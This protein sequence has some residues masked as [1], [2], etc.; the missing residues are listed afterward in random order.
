MS[1]EKNSENRVYSLRTR[2]PKPPKIAEEIYFQ[3]KACLKKN[4]AYSSK[5][6]INQPM[7]KNDKPKEDS[8]RN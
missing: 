5:D 2:I 4:R 8:T 6:N 7:K 1:D 3:P